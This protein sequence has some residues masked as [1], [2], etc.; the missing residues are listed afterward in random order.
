MSNFLDNLNSA[1]NEGEFNSNAA[2]KILDITKHTDENFSNN[3]NADE[4]DALQEAIT[5]RLE[6]EVVSEPV[7]EKIA[8]EANT[9]Y[10]LKMAQFKKQDAANKQLATLIEIEDMVELSISDMFIFIESC[11]EAFDK[12][13]A[14]NDPMFMELKE[15][16]SEIN[17][18][19]KSN[20]KKQ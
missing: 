16:I 6:D 4:V 13:L 20:I 2:K 9:E 5:E 7:N 3:L 19:F 11:N 12:E 18:K 17:S 15:K 1:V 8:L 10:E 14:A